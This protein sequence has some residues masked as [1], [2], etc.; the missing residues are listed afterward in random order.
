MKIGCRT[1]DADTEYLCI[2]CDCERDSFEC[3]I[4]REEAETTIDVVM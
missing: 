1:N 3:G 4:F 2:D